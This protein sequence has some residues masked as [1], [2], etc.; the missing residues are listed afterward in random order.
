MTGCPS[1][2][3]GFSTIEDARAYMKRNGVTKPKEVIK[4]GAGD[5]TPLRDREAFYAVAHG[6]Q[7]GIYSY[8]KYQ[9]PMLSDR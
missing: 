8:W 2:H 1:V 7:P 6:K 3:K 9:F 5:T 4:D